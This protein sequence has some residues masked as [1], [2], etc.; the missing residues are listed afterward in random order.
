MNIFNNLLDF[1]NYRTY[2]IICGDCKHQSGYRNVVYKL[3][4]DVSFLEF[5]RNFK[6]DNGC[7]TSPSVYE[8][9]SD[10]IYN[11]GTMDVEDYIYCDIYTLDTIYKKYNVTFSSILCIG[12]LI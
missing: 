10:F 5:K 3:K 7:Y 1:F 8:D 9:C 11:N 12:L 4:Q 2:L 6:L